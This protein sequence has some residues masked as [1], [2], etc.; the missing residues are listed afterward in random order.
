MKY[1]LQLGRRP[2]GGGSDNFLPDTDQD[3]ELDEFEDL[4]EEEEDLVEDDEAL[5]EE[6][7]FDRPHFRRL[8]LDYEEEEEE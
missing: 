7:N 3:E 8:G 2:K 5:D 6:L 1:Q 4:G